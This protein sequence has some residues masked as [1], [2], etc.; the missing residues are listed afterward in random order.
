MPAG[1]RLF[2]SSPKITA[3]TSPWRK[4]PR[5]STI[6]AQAWRALWTIYVWR[7]ATS[8]ST[9]SVHWLI[10][11][12]TWPVCSPHLLWLSSTHLPEFQ[13]TCPTGT[14]LKCFTGRVD[15]GRPLF[16]PRSRVRLL[17]CP[18]SFATCSRNLFFGIYGTSW[19]SI[20]VGQYG[21][22][23][24]HGHLPKLHFP[25]FDGEHPKLCI[26]WAHS[27]FD[28]YSVEPHLWIRVSSMHFTGLAACWFSAQD[29]QCSLLP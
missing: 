16:I 28:M 19:R 6:G 26:R 20:A 11:Q 24:G 5:C 9:G 3:A 8:P 18:C 22:G 7:W 1:R 27:Y 15:S 10:S 2:R 21:G 25:S 29:D 23:S 14:A 4:P 17:Q 12:P 13:P